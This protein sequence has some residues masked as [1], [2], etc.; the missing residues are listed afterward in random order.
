MPDFAVLDDRTL[1]RIVGASTN[2][3]W[4]AGSAVFEP[5]ARTE[6]LYVVLSGKVLIYETADGEEREVISVGPGGFFGEHSVLFDTE[7]SK[8]AR[9]VEPSELMIVPRESFQAI[10]AD[11]PEIVAHLMARIET[12]LTERRPG[13]T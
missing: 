5:G 4:P 1:L 3:V 7:H 12:R 2:L 8:R 9:A 11:H 10:M 6:G 13:T